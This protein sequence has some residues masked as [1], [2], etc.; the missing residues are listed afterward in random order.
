MHL[1]DAPVLTGWRIRRRTGNL[2][3]HTKKPAA[4]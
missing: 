1:I 2:A 4:E 3:P